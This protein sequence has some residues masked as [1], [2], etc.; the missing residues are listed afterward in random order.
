[1]N[2]EKLLDIIADID[3]DLIEKAENP[4]SKKKTMIYYLRYCALAAVICLAVITVAMAFGS[5]HDR[6]PVDITTP[7]TGTDG[8]NITDP[9]V[10]QPETTDLFPIDDNSPQPGINGLDYILTPSPNPA[11]YPSCGFRPENPTS[12]GPSCYDEYAEDTRNYGHNHSLVRIKIIGAYS[13]EEAYALTGD[14]VFLRSTTLFKAVITYNY[15]TE[16]P[17]ELEINLAHAGQSDNQISG[18]PLYMPD[19]E[20]I[21]YLSSGESGYYVAFMEFAV[22]NVSGIELAYQ[23]GD[24]SI[25]LESNYVTTQYN[26]LDLAMDESERRVT[27]STANNPI[28]YTYKMTVSDLVGFIREDWS[29]RGFTFEGFTTPDI[30]NSANW[31]SH[32]EHHN[33]EIIEELPKL[34]FS[35]PSASRFFEEYIYSEVKD[36]LLSDK[37]NLQLIEF[38]ITDMCPCPPEGLSDDM[39]DGTLYGISIL[40]DYLTGDTTEKSASLW[41]YG[42][43]TKQ[44]KG[45][46]V[47]KMGERFIAAVYT[48][49]NCILRPIYDLEFLLTESPL[50][51][52]IYAYHIGYYNRIDIAIDGY[53]LETYLGELEASRYGSCENNKYWFT[54][55][56]IPEILAEYL[57]THWIITDSSM[58]AGAAD[59]EEEEMMPA[60]FSTVEGLIYA[61]N[62]GDVPAV[63]EEQKQALKTVTDIEYFYAPT[64]AFEGYKLLRIAVSPWNIFYYYVPKD[65]AADQFSYDSGI[66]VCYS[67][68]E[69]SDSDDPLKALTEQA[70]IGLTEDGLMYEPG[71]QSITFT[72]GSSWMSI[73]V[74]ESMNEYEALK[75]LCKAE[76]IVIK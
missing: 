32:F 20:Y 65:G 7:T 35:V 3:A 29:A 64:A 28:I 34:N 62:G 55:K 75:K 38:E 50:D 71:R 11:I 4:V 42:N 69:S 15:L 74:P 48:D 12:G 30:D 49:E 67:R 18:Y 9:D 16:S 59:L 60:V 36:E 68:E 1:M 54:Q 45:Y 26:N 21:A 25:K 37:D 10:L 19:E 43:G 23:I 53:E 46:P 63:N 17:M 58:P 5:N 76:K 57:R 14:D 13:T 44:Y 33:V 52:E 31:S 22:Y 61:A 66:S 41:H 24:K 70:G 8:T 40:R 72:A 39:T 56:F 51:G 47:F 2:G 6:L 27:T 73:R